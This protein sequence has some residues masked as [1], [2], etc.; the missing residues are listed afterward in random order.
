MGTDIQRQVLE[1]GDKDR[2]S[3]GNHLLSAL[4]LVHFG[5]SAKPAF[6]AVLPRSRS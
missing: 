1:F 4:S 3:P 2:D 5:V 6:G